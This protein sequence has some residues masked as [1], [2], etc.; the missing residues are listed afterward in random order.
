MCMHKNGLHH[1]IHIFEY[2]G[3]PMIFDYKFEFMSNKNLRI[4]F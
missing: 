1:K 4:K 2:T 3:V